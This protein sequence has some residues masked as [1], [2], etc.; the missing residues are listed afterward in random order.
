MDF[1]PALLLGL[2]GLELAVLA[3][4]IGHLL[5]AWLLGVPV[6]FHVGFG[7]AVP[8]GRRRWGRFTYVLSVLPVGG[9][10]AA[11][12]PD[13]AGP[14]HIW[15][16]VVVALGGIVA[17]GLLAW[18]CFTAWSWHGPERRAGVVGAVEPG[19]PAWTKDIPTGAEIVQA[20]DKH[21]P[22]YPDLIKLVRDTGAGKELPLAYARPG[23][24]EPTKV[25]VEL[26]PDPDGPNPKE[27]RARLGILPPSRLQL[28]P[29]GPKTEVETPAR[30][31]SPAARA[32][33]P[34][35]FGDTIVAVTD[36]DRGGEVTDLPA[37]PWNP[38]GGWHDIQE[39]TRRQRL[40]AGK[41][42]V[43]RVRRAGGGTADVK[44]PPSFYRTFGARMEMGPVAA[45]REGSSAARAGLRAGDRIVRVEVIEP[46]TGKPRQLAE[47][48]LD[49]LR[50]PFELRQWAERV[51]RKGS[52]ATEAERAVRVEVSRREGQAKESP[53]PPVSLEWDAS[54]R[55]ENGEPILSLSAPLAIPELGLAYRVSNHVAAGAAEGSS[56]LEDQDAI[57]ALKLISVGPSEDKRW[58]TLKRDQ[59]AAAFQ[60]LQRSD[61]GPTVKAKV[62]RRA[63]ETQELDLKLS[64]DRSWPIVSRGLLLDRETRRQSAEG[65]GQAAELGLKRVRTTLERGWD[66]VQQRLAGDKDKV[67]LNPP[68]PVTINQVPRNRSEAGP[69]LFLLLLGVWCLNLA[70]INL[71]PI[72]AL[73]GGEVVLLV[74]EKLRGRPLPDRARL[75]AYGLGTVA[76]LVLVTLPNVLDLVERLRPAAEQPKAVSGA[77]NP[78]RPW[79]LAAR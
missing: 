1:L 22:A 37:D 42:L 4:M 50:L 29:K 48:T 18:G 12:D 63:G 30:P 44:I 75:A 56:G 28:I 70:V 69:Y 15:R 36:P 33:P 77:D 10:V 27:K 8:G 9:Y 38:V 40:L 55:L 49:P 35:E 23:D 73:D 71:L 51:A 54:R 74:Y 6:E 47:A 20:G 43:L 31:G 57:I 67:V 78:A 25:T 58:L 66:S 61:V 24:K 79:V 64:E 7:P 59:F 19:S 14:P 17:S 52:A 34:L 60:R 46:E 53:L 39:F 76:V 45:V 21:H 11:A 13:E 2:L 26:A 62:R 3:H 32:E 68:V 72:P 41:E 65:A 16:R 5:T